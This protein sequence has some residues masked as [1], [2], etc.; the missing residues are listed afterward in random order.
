[1]PVV[2]SDYCKKG[3][4]SIKNKEFFELMPVSYGTFMP[5]DGKKSYLYGKEVIKN[6]DMVILFEEC[7][8]CGGR[9]TKQALYGH[10]APLAAHQYQ[11]GHYESI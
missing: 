6:G 10:T 2:I 7:E 8:S 5:L 9:K 1:M 3:N 11:E 4:F